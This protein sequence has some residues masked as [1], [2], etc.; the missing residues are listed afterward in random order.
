MGDGHDG[1]LVLV[2]VALEPRDRLGVEVVRGLVEQEE[3]GGAQQQPAQRDAAAL[4]AGEA[5]DVGVGRREAQ[6]VHGL[7]EAGVEVP[8]VDG[9]DALLERGELV[10][11]LLGVVHGQLVEAVEHVLDL[12]HAVLDVAAHVLG[13]VE[14]GLLLEEADG[15]VGGEHRVAAVLLVDAGHD[16]QDRRL[17]GAVVAEHADLRARE[18]RERDVL[19]HLLVRREGPAEA[20]H[21]EDVLVGHGV[22]GSQWRY[23]A[24]VRRARCAGL[25]SAAASGRRV[26]AGS[27]EERRSMARAG[28]WFDEHQDEGA[29]AAPA[30]H[31]DETGGTRLEA[32]LCL[33]PRRRRHGRA[34]PRPPPRAVHRR[35]TASWRSSS[36]AARASRGRVTVVDVAARDARTTGATQGDEVAA[37]ACRGRR[38]RRRWPSRFAEAHRGRLRARQHRPHGRRQGMPTLLWLAA[39]AREYR[40]VLRLTTPPAGGPADACSAAAGAVLARLPGR[41][42]PADWLHGDAAP[43]RAAGRTACRPPPRR[44]RAA[45]RPLHPGVPGT[46]YASAA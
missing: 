21:L 41:D 3:V 7:V 29:R 46:P 2:E 40:D 36:T 14:L 28:D 16:P 9:V 25:A 4:A 20:V 12:A 17:A 45:S 11:R 35:S 19:E 23:L 18:E 33:Q 6:R 38:A 1:A 24:H 43:A 26:A 39:M 8:G 42:P 22:E 32:E 37:R 5:G 15:R 27:R 13:L 31:R 34:R 44:S 30:C 10:G